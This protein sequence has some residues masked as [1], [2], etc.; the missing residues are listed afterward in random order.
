[1]AR[2][3]SAEKPPR[4]ESGAAADAASASA[5]VSTCHSAESLKTAAPGRGADFDL[6]APASPIGVSPAGANVASGHRAGLGIRSGVELPLPQATP[7]ASEP[8]SLNTIYQLETQIGIWGRGPWAFR[9]HH[10]EPGPSLDSPHRLPH[11]ALAVS[12]RVRS[13]ALYG[14]RTLVRRMGLTTRRRPPA[15]RLYTYDR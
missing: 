15:R 9:S 11:L 7:A 4:A 14:S 3:P 2:R 5:R 1:M 8:G 6:A 10:E 13:L 12:A